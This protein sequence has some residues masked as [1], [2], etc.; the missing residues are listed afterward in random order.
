MTCFRR[1]GLTEN[2]TGKGP[3]VSG[4]Q[5]PR[6]RDARGKQGQGYRR[7][8]PVVAVPPAEQAEIK[9]IIDST[10]ADIVI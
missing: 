2:L 3:A 9:A 10:R 7:C 5:Q 8:E 6:Q 4:D 1:S